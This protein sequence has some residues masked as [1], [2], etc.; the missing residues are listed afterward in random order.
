MKSLS[1]KSVKN[2]ILFFGMGLVLS[3]GLIS[4]DNFLKGTDVKN[5]LEEAIEIA[6][7]SPVTFNLKADENSG[8]VIPA[9]L[10]L[11]KREKF[12]ISFEPAENIIFVKWEVIDTDTGLPV[13]GVLEFDD[14]TALETS[15]K[16]INPRPR[17]IIHPKC[18]IQPGV[19]SYSPSDPLK[20]NFAN[21]PIIINF[22]I[23]MEAKDTKPEDSQFNF[24][25]IKISYLAPDKSTVDL[26]SCFQPPSFD[27]E[28]KVLKIIP[29]PVAL[30]N[31]I[32]TLNYI[33]VNVSISPQIKCLQDNI[34]LSIKQN[35]LLNFKVRYK[36]E[37]EVV[38]PVIVESSLFAT[39]VPINLENYKNISEEEK[40]SQTNRRVVDSLYIYGRYYDADSGVNKVIVTQSLAN[41]IHEYTSENAQF[42]T[43][44]NG[45]TD[46][47]LKF[48]LDLTDGFYDIQVT[49][50]DA[51][52]N[53]SLPQSFEIENK[54]FYN[55]EDFY[56][57]VTNE[58]PD[59]DHFWM[60]WEQEEDFYTDFVESLQENPSKLQTFIQEFNQNIKR[61]KIEDLF[62]HAFGQEYSFQDGVKVFCEY[63]DKKGL[64]RK[65]QFI[66]AADQD[67]YYVD[68]D[69]DHIPSVPL[70][71]IV[72]DSLG[73]QGESLIRIEPVR[74]KDEGNYINFYRMQDD[75]RINK[76]GGL[77]IY[78]DSQNQ[79]NFA[80]LYSGGQFVIQSSDG[81]IPLCFYV[82]DNLNSDKFPSC[83]QGV[84]YSDLLEF[85]EQSQLSITAHSV[86]PDENNHA[87]VTFTLDDNTCL[88]Y[89]KISIIPCDGI[90]YWLDGQ[91]KKLP[92]QI[93]L[94]D[95]E[96][97]S[98]S[99]TFESNY[100]TDYYGNPV[101]F[102]NLEH[103][104]YPV[105]HNGFIFKLYPAVDFYTPNLANAAECLINDDLDE[106]AYDDRPPYLTYEW[107]SYDKIKFTLADTSGVKAGRL[108][109]SAGELVAVFSSGSLSYT[110]KATTFYS[111]MIDNSS[112]RYK[113]LYSFDS[114][115]FNG[116][117]VENQELTI[118]GSYITGDSIEWL[119]YEND[120]IYPLEECE[121]EE[122]YILNKFYNVWKWEEINF[123]RNG[124]K[125]SLSGTTQGTY[126]KFCQS[127]KEF[128][129][130]RSPAYK[131]G[132]D[133]K[134]TGD[135]DYMFPAPYAEHTMLISSDAPVFVHRL[136]TRLPYDIC[137][138]W[139]VSEWCSYGSEPQAGMK[140]LDFAPDDTG[141]KKYDYGEL[142]EG[143]NIIIVHF[144]NGDT[145]ISEIF[146]KE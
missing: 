21:T 4:C 33:D 85:P 72:Q 104:H 65:D 102:K 47:C 135:Y 68:L 78:K 71:F 103:Y 43:D 59:L 138:D 93:A 106:S 45:N 20:T 15:G 136:Y 13:T 146:T 140:L 10:R 63:T 105:T 77:S 42:F 113:I 98:V 34:E 88:K 133:S 52:E 116:N 86:S 60:E 84:I 142:D 83:F 28:K 139:N 41:V 40:I 54:T 114:E 99:Y 64:L 14:E 124:N 49:V 143:N 74:L 19:L 110:P 129:S 18:I 48:D 39:T 119:D 23:P 11:K 66:K 32:G 80:T 16:V 123:T 7:S 115:D 121:I 96:N 31:V 51:C 29:D 30:R 97:K 17:C 36:A 128:Y 112:G 35:E 24:T 108:R 50:Q 137:K 12:D 25:N 67:F 87:V 38:E 122:V 89:D 27:K 141:P 76:G 130:R 6:N 145:L 56:I 94:V 91:E 55:E 90:Y 9:Q 70:K 118:E 61:L 132:G 82:Y 53:Y 95:K 111:N 117:K 46:F 3:A 2:T 8:N 126:V 134:N 109:N 101:F 92:G 75:E 57:F 62:I 69:I 73:C 120:C 26:S 125:L 37:G 107:E 22:N 81:E 58:P 79:Y 100:Y 1:F 5:R 127:G 44:E 144:A 131:Y